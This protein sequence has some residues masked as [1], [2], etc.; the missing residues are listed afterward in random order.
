MAKLSRLIRHGVGN[1]I[2]DDGGGVDVS[3][4]GGTLTSETEFLP[5]SVH[6]LALPSLRV[7][8]LAAVVAGPWCEDS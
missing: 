8:C 3:E 4:S 5:F 6:R 7:S 2:C 1:R